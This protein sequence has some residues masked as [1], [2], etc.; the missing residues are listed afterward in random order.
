MADRDSHGRLIGDGGPARRA[1][2]FVLSM[3]FLPV[4]LMSLLI[5][6]PAKRLADPRFRW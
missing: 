3:F 1:C 4:L 6:P 2:L 5:W